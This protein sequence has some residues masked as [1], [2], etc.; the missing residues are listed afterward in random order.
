MY[1]KQFEKYQMLRA[2][3]EKLAT[4]NVDV[5]HA[6]KRKINEFRW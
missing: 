1:I 6:V 2:K 5:W 3:K 4:K